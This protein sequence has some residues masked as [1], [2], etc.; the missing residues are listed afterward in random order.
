M[1]NLLFV[2]C[3]CSYTA[4][5]LTFSLS[6]YRLGLGYSPDLEFLFGQQPIKICNR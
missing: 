1:R 2:S 3:H 4:R 6:H 5:L